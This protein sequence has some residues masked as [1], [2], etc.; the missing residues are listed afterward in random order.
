[1]KG[2]P[3]AGYKYTLNENGK[4]VDYEETGTGESE[5]MTDVLARKTVDIIERSADDD[6]PFFIYLSTYAPH[7]PV[8]PAP[9][10]LALLPDLKAPRTPSFNEEDVSDKPLETSSDPLL[11]EE[12]VHKIDRKY[13]DRVLTMLAVDEM[14]EQVFDA[15]SATG[16]LENTY[17]I[18]TSDNGFHMGQHRRREGKGSFY[19]ED[20][21]VPLII[22]GP[23]IEAGATVDGYV[24]G[25][26]DLAPTIAEL[27]G[28]VPPEYV[29]GRSLVKLLGKDIPLVNEWRSAFLLEFYGYN[30]VEE[31]AAASQ[32]EEQG[33]NPLSPAYLG[34]RTPNY[35]YVEH[36]DGFIELYDLKNDPYELENMAS[37]ADKNLLTGLSNLLHVLSECSGAQCNSPASSFME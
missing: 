16:Q 27:A 29:D 35:L 34:L 32:G 23:G 15:L 28:V 9:R 24:T 36:Q 5:Y 18:F 20:I 33:I 37:S 17:I 31:G 3:V 6:A 1:V 2:S 19:E 13:R 30:N 22:R 8:Q 12:E 4:Q 11:T 10:H 14:I 25:N 21:H 7:A 26:I